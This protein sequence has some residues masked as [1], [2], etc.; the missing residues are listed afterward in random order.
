MIPFFCEYTKAVLRAACDRLGLEA[1]LSATK[2]DL[3]NALCR[4]EDQDAARAAVAD[5]A[6]E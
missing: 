3:I 1:S 2:E 6:G 4:L 5:A